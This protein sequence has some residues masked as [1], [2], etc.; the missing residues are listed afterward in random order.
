MPVY[1]QVAE[2]VNIAITADK[3]EVTVG[4]PVQLTVEITH[5]TGYLVI[6]PKLPREWGEVKVRAQ[7]TPETVASGNGNEI[8]RQRITVSRFMT[9]T[10]EV[11]TM[12]IVIK[13][14][15]GQSFGKVSPPFS[16]TVL[17]VLT[18]DDAELHDLKPQ[19]SLPISRWWWGVVAL[20]ILSMGAL[21]WWLKRKFYKI[22]N[23]K[24]EV[25][26]PLDPRPPHQIALEELAQI[27]QL[28]LPEQG[29]FKEHYILVADCFRTYLDRR[30]Q[31]P[32]MDLTTSEIKKKLEKRSKQ[33]EVGSREY[34]GRST[35]I[36]HS[37]L[38][39]TPYSLL[40]IPKI[41]KLLNE[42]DLGKFAKFTPEIQEA[43]QVIEQ[44]RL[45][46]EETKETASTAPNEQANIHSR[47]S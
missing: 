18:P 9:G 27:K 22:R 34:E 32:A 11:P 46:V 25:Q 44:S 33:Y 12:T 16:F 39:L 14:A 35:E 10:V 42:C 38:L 43:Y 21:A 2:G 28:A 20:A 17:S 30:Y 31:I 4:D 41:V 47:Q 45:L 7:A 1:A 24:S 37:S 13:D 40:L 26:S 36:T 23:Q 29:R 8:T 15:H 6:L 19:A 5:P 3:T